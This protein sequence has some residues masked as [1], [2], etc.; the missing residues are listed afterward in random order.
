MQPS[1]P[2]NETSEDSYRLLFESNPH[3][4]WVYDRESLAF[5]AVNDAAIQHYGYSRA[6]FLQRTI[7]DIRP[8]TDVAWLEQIL[9]QGPRG[10]KQLARHLK[11]DGTLI[12]VEVSS[13]PLTFAGRTA[14]LVLANDITERHRAEQQVQATNALLALAAQK[15]TP[16]DYL[17]GVVEWFRD[18]TGCQ[19][20]G[21]RLLDEHGHIPYEAY[22]GFSQEFWAQE[23]TIVVGR[24]HCLCTRVITETPSALEMPAITPAGTFS[25]CRLSELA[26][27]LP[28]LNPTLYRGTCLRSGFESM[29]ILPLRHEGRIVGVIHVADASPD[30]M[31]PLV[32]AMME[33]LAPLISSSLHRLQLASALR[34][35]EQNLR[36][37]ERMAQLG[38]WDWN[39]ATGRGRWSDETFRIL[40]LVR[41]VIDPEMNTFLERVHPEDRGGVWEALAEGLAG[42]DHAELEFRI[43]RPDGQIRHVI[44]TGEIAPRTPGQPDW[45]FGTLLD[46]TDRHLAAQALRESEERY[47][48]LFEVESDAILVI[49]HQTELFIDANPAAVEMYGYS[50]VELQRLKFFQLSAE[51]EQSQ[52]TFERR[53][54][55]VQLRWHRKKDGTVFPV[56][57]ALSYSDISGRSVYV[58]AIRDITERRHI[59]EK[60]QQ[61][62]ERLR[63]AAE[64]SGFGTYDYEFA[65]AAS[66]WSPE[67]RK[68]WGVPPEKTVRF[69]VPTLLAELHPDDRGSFHEAMR[70]ATDPSG[71]GRFRQDFRVVHPDGTAHWL[72][73]CGRTF[74]AGEGGERHRTRAMGVVLDI[75]ERK[76]TEEALRQSAALLAAAQRLAHIGSWEWNIAADTVRWSKAMYHIFAIDPSQPARHPQDALELIHPE[77][78]SRMRQSVRDALAGTRVF[79]VRYRTLLPSGETRFLHT[80]GEVTRQPGGSPVA[81]VGIVYD[82]TESVLAEEA[83]REAQAQERRHLRFNETLLAATPIPVFYKDATGRYLGCNPAFTEATGLTL[84]DIRGKQV[85]EILPASIAAVHM[86]K[87]QEIDRYPSLTQCY[88]CTILSKNGEARKGLMAKRAFLDEQGLVEG[89]VG[90]FTDIT[91]RLQAE[92]ELRESRERLKALSRRL[93]ELDETAR[94]NLARELH[95]RVGQNLTSLSINLSIMQGLLPAKSA[96]RIGQRLEDSMQLVSETMDRVRDV[97]AD[98][99]PAVLDDY[100]LAAAL[101]W[102]GARFAERTGLTVEVAG[103]DP[104]PRLPAAAEI[105]LFRIVQEALTNVARH[106]QARQVRILLA[107]REG[108]ITLEIADDGI[109]FDPANTGPRGGQAAWGLATMRER[110][111]SVGAQFRVDTAPGKG[112]NISVQ[113]ACPSE[114]LKPPAVEPPVSRT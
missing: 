46:I 2:Q 73:V 3:P 49:N 39:P 106:A 108:C 100:G 77:D 85:H 82:I 112:A 27:T 33:Q 94:H 64:A 79:D 97:M 71:D 103:L 70:I 60:L 35:S 18:Y 12:M 7:K 76:R 13:K 19:C 6:E 26:G 95:D 101:R 87:D 11:R 67:L 78:R 111:E 89:L 74:F 90:A 52:K 1:F 8:T 63:L 93:V 22:V 24:D 15:P 83:L 88:E 75:T 36:R 37:A 92:E 9:E 84:A 21:I 114:T 55:R 81:M 57:I 51:P 80:R 50:L 5:L 110:A 59:E 113:L 29:A 91:E 23:N 61:S 102:S 4:M 96:Q 28:V 66:H 20:V 56:E 62:E 38:Y 48:R 65:T 45:W 104:V 105:A 47:R 72:H 99:R 54:K 98:L 107:V 109:G 69:D 42:L 31:P 16:Q 41:P 53:D 30:L 40:G 10:L 86:E 58:A 14:R 43:V 32:V 68:L 17:H 44:V 25:T 34:E